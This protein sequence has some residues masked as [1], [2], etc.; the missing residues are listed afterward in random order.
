MGP[1]RMQFVAFMLSLTAA[2]YQHSYKATAAG[3][4]VHVGAHFRSTCVFLYYNQETRS[5]GKYVL[6]LSL[7]PG[8]NGLGSFQGTVR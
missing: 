5:M 1:L 3:V 7:P 2:S 4:V 6:C 8:T